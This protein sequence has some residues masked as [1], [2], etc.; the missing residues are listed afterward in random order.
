[1][2]GV[3][4]TL[5][6]PAV[7]YATMETCVYLI[8]LDA[9]ANC[10]G[11]FGKAKKQTLELH[12]VFFQAASFAGRILDWLVSNQTFTW[13]GGFPKEKELFTIMAEKRSTFQLLATRSSPPIDAR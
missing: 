13:A 2:E 7:L 8:F 10:T 9:R 3:V 12:Q 6:S 11:T 1:V 4:T 5:F